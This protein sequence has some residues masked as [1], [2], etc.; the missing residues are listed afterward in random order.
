ML[1]VARRCVLISVPN[2]G[3]IPSMSRHLVVPW[4]VLEATHVNFFTE[5]ILS[6]YLRDIDGVDGQVFTY[7]AFQLNGDVYHN[8]VFA[9]VRKTIGIGDM[10]LTR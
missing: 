1:R 9:V 2:I 5:D 4:H 8:H 6:R 7:G 3:V 10:G